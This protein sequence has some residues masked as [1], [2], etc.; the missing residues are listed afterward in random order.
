MTKD[1]MKYVAKKMQNH[2]NSFDPNNI[3]DYIDC[4]ILEAKR[5]NQKESKN[6]HFFQDSANYLSC[7]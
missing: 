7:N 4:F 3:R 5:L 1:I 2:E 6:Q